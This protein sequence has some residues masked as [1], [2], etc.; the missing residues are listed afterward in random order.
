MHSFELLESIPGSL[1]EFENEQ[2]MILPAD[3]RPY[4]IAI[5]LH[6][7]SVTLSDAVASISPHCEIDDLKV[8]AWNPL[9]Q[10][11]CDGTRLE[12]VIDFV[13]QALLNDGVVDYDE[14]TETWSLVPGEITKIIAWVTTLDA[15]LPVSLIEKIYQ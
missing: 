10:D 9:T 5:L 15:S 4:V 12:A 1:G 11:Y 13:L 8:G 6:R 7:G 3:A 14:S 2:P